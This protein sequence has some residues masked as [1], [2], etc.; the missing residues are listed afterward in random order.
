MTRAPLQERPG[1][2]RVLGVTTSW[3]RALCDCCSSRRRTRLRRVSSNPWITERTGDQNLLGFL[4]A[5]KRRLE[6]A[7]DDKP[8][9]PEEPK[10]FLKKFDADSVRAR[11]ASTAVM[12]LVANARRTAKVELK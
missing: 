12:A 10:F 1:A 6:K 9:Q 3:S 7:K 8:A 4:E 5:E 2:M 11:L